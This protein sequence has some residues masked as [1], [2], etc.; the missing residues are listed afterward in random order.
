MSFKTLRM[1]SA[2]WPKQNMMTGASL[3]HASL[4][5]WASSISPDRERKDGERKRGGRER[6]RR[7]TWSVFRR[8]M[9]VSS[10]QSL[11]FWCHRLGTG[12]S[13][14]RCNS[15]QRLT[16]SRDRRRDGN[17]RKS[18][19]FLI[20]TWQRNFGKC[21]SV[22]DDGADHSHLALRGTACW[23]VLAVPLVHMIISE[24]L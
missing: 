22:N 2:S 11:A 24:C 23:S 15:Y 12:L 9:T 7:G 8:K 18:T 3:R 16:H 13:V 14:L 4:Y 21:G 6:E 17:T 1:F 5:L 20:Y 19:R 10:C